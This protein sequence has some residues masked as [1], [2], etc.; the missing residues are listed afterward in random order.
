M[1]KYGGTKRRHHRRHGG[2]GFSNMSSKKA[3]EYVSDLSKKKNK[4]ELER[5]SAAVHS[6]NPYKV[7]E[8]EGT[9]SRTPSPMPAAQR[10]ITERARSNSER[11]ED[12]VKKEGAARRRTRKHKKHGRKTRHRR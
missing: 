1:Y 5:L 11:K 3:D 8:G 6:G 12:E 10:V 7:Y 4:E 9:E 2:V